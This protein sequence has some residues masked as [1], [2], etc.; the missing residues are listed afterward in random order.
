MGDHARFKEKGHLFCYQ[1]VWE[2]SFVMYTRS[3][4]RTNDTEIMH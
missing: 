4:A 1:A 3:F 2:I